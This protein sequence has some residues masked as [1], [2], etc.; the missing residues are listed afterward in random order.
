MNKAEL[1]DK[2]AEKTGI[3]PK[4]ARIVMDALFDP[5]PT[6]GLIAAELV[7]G[8]KVAISGFGTFMVAKR[9][10]RTGRDPRTGKEILIPPAK[11]PRFRPSRGLKAGIR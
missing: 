9:A 5:D 6:I 8:G 7:A 11:V 10:A 3:A 2:L 1:T 4:D